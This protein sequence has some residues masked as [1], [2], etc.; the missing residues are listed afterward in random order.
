M[1]E[2][3]RRLYVP[4][5][6]ASPPPP[7]GAVAVIDITSADCRDALLAH[8]CPDCD[9]PDCVVLARVNNW[10]VGFKLEDMQD[11]PTSPSDDQAHGIARIDNSARTA[12]ASTQ[13]ITEAL[14]CLMDNGTGGGVGPAGPSGPPGPPGPAGAA[15]PAGPTGPAGA[16]GPQGPSGLRTD[17]TGICSVSWQQKAIPNGAAGGGI[18][19][20]ADLEKAPLT[21]AFSGKVETI[22]L[23][24]QSVR[25]LASFAQSSPLNLVVWGEVPLTLSPINLATPCNVRSNATAVTAGPGVT[26][27]AV[28]LAVDI[29][30]IIEALRQNQQLSLRVEVHGDLIRDDQGLGLDGNHLPP[31]LPTVNKTGDGV[32]GGLFES[33]FTLKLG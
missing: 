11:P 8:E 33:W 23:T 1:T 7:A 4:Y 13:A 14:L 28:R 19:T 27:N 17:L 16:T 22:D 3:G 12:L 10:K 6:G 25:L 18:L 21:I 2:S 20:L 15:G 9:T 5:S 29:N 31:W 24:S 30:R 26:C 32:A